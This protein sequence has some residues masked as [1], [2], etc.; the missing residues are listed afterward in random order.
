VSAGAVS[1]AGL[2]VPGRPLVLP[3]AWD[4]ASA[5]ALVKAGFTAVGTTSLGVAGAA[6]LPDGQGR[7]WPQTLALA[8]RLTA[9]PCR[10]SVDIEG[11]F[12]RPGEVAGALAA[13]GVAGVN[14]EDGLPDGGLVPVGTQAERIAEARAAAPGLFL[15]A[16]TDTHWL[17]GAPDLGETLDR[18]RAYVEAGADG[19]FVPGLADPADIRTVVR[20]AGRP[21]NLL[22]L[23][24]GRT[25]AELGTLGVAR[26]STG[27][28][29]FR[30]ALGAAVQ[31]AR[32]VAAGEPVATGLPSYPEVAAMLG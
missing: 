24:G 1:F 9:L 15:N 22:A 23:A 6:G 21:L 29:L 11:G 20:A 17:T 19:V 2:H 32:A 5:A 25:V 3:N 7:T 8:E 10:L 12:G 16:R 27:S 31:T 30:A 26:V 4:F 28:L 14:L 13:L 18:L